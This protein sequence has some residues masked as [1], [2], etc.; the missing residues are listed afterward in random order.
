MNKFLRQSIA[1]LILV[2]LIFTTLTA[3]SEE[4]A[5]GSDDT[6]AASNGT[7][8][9][10][11]LESTDKAVTDDLP[12]RDFEGHNFMIYSLN[13]EGNTWYTTAYT[14]AQEDSAE[15]IESAIYNRNL[16]VAERFNITIGETFVTLNDIN[17]SIMASDKDFD[18][19][20]MKGV[21]AL[22]LGQKKSLYDLTTLEYINF[23][24]PYWDQNAR[25]ELTIANQLYIGVGDFM[26]TH[27]DETIVMYFNKA[28]ITDFDLESPYDLVAE[29]RWTYD[30]MFE[31]GQN[32][33]Q[34]LDGDGKF[35]DNDRF[36]MISLGGLVY[37][38]LIIGSGEQYL[39]KDE[40]DLPYIAFNS[41]RF[42]TVYEKVVTMMHSNSDTFLYDAGLRSNTKGLSSNHRVQEIMFPNNQA[43]FWIECTS[44]SKALRDM[45]ADFGII[46]APKYE[47]TQSRYY[48]YCNPNFYA[49]TIPVTTD[50]ERAS[51]IAEA[52]NSES[53]STVLSAYYYITLKTKYSRDE[54]SQEMLDLIFSNRMYN[55]GT[56]YFDS[57]TNSAIANRAAN[58]NTDIASYYATVQKSLTK[59][60]QK[61]V[62]ALTGSEN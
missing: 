29:N 21:D 32:V 49:I 9:T 36:A 40:S 26:T 60:I 50:V 11:S 5:A 22:T 42:A 57:S 10:D 15:V 25:N 48:N 6:T 34:D 54:Q 43:L 28:L 31:M 4:S 62:D 8:L 59:S 46:P 23:D 20:L 7:T 53:T 1:V 24:K 58:N 3:C 18:I 52:L 13:S 56:V 39:A 17:N 45:D 61:I 51:I 33:I 19:A 35:D 27:I 37:P 2:G 30:K 47:E 16:K 38:Y 55:V 41:D 12:E 44:W 14:T